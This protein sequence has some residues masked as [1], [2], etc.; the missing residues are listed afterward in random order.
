MYDQTRNDYVMPLL[1]IEAQF[2]DEGRITFSE[3]IEGLDLKGKRVLI[4]VLATN[5]Y[6]EP[7]SSGR[8]AAL[9]SQSVLARYRD[10]PEED[11]AWAHFQNPEEEI[12]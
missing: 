6:E 4:T 5:L 3:E 7:I 2:D 1:T 8:Y 9:M 11:E 12:D 10:T